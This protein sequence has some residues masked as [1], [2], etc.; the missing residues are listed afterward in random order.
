MIESPDRKDDFHNNLHEKILNQ[1]IIL[2][3]K[4]EISLIK[5]KINMVFQW[6]ILTRVASQKTCLCKRSALFR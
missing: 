4:L 2:L 3:S 1:N 6:R 5:Q